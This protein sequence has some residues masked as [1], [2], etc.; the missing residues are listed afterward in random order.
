MQIEKLEWKEV[1]VKVEIRQ[2]EV[3]VALGYERER[4]YKGGERRWMSFI[5][6]KILE[7]MNECTMEVCK[8]KIECTRGS[9][10]RGNYTQ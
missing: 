2:S 10:R 8:E 9:K 5:A 6:C 4:D 7:D 3:L 1:K